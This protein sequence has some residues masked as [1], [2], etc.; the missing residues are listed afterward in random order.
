MSSDI[1]LMPGETHTER[2]LLNYRHEINANA[3]W[4]MVSRRAPQILS[5]GVKDT[6]GVSAMLYFHVDESAVPSKA[7]FQPWVNQ[8]NSPDP[9]TRFEAARVL[10]SVAPRSW[11][12]LLLTFADNWEFRTLVPLALHRLNTT[13]S[14]AA[15]AVFAGKTSSGTFE[16][17]Q[18]TAH[19]AND[20]CADEF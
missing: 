6:L 20:P 18:A 14:N 19:L 12:E 5:H 10:A 8:L 15:M 11:E 17:W 3:Y 7:D 13:R 2:I 9:I 1:E 16:H 4:V